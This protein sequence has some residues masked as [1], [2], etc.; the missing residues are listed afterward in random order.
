MKIS[1]AEGTFVFGKEKKKYF[2]YSLHKVKEVIY[3]VFKDNTKQVEMSKELWDVQTLLQAEESYLLTGGWTLNLQDQKMS[4]TDNIRRILNLNQ[5]TTPS[6]ELFVEKL[7]FSDS[8]SPSDIIAI[9][10]EQPGRFNNEADVLLDSGIKKHILLQADLSQGPDGEKHLLGFLHDTTESKLNKKDFGNLLSDLW[11]KEAF[12]DKLLFNETFF[13]MKI[14]LDGTFKSVNK[15]YSDLFFGP[16]PHAIENYNPME[17]IAIE[18]HGNCMEGVEKAL[19]NPGRNVKV[20]LRKYTWEKKEIFTRWDF[21][22]LVDDKNLPMEILCIGI[23]ITEIEE[24]KRELRV[25][26][27]LASKQ[28]TQLIEYNSILSHNIR[29]HVANLKGLSNLIELT[30]NPKDI[31][32]YFGLI[33]EAIG[34]LDQ[35]I[36]SFNYLNKPKIEGD[37]EKIPLSS[38]IAN[39]KAFFEEELNLIE[40]EFYTIGDSELL[41]TPFN[42]ILERILIQLISNCIKFRSPKRGLIIQIKVL[43]KA[44]NFK[45]SVQDNG[46]GIDLKRNNVNTYNSIEIKNLEPNSRGFGIFIASS[47]TESLG[48]NLKFISKKDLGTKINL[49]ISHDW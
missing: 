40:A 30:N 22:A 25:L 9:C 42:S 7:K 36:T 28:N 11:K 46:I 35:R 5:E 4:W 45:I 2:T 37:K 49:T 16:G 41:N 38:I 18:D 12:I 1:T 48:G 34:N 39:C 10:M 21:K 15:L 14:S 20:Y 29:N 43:K 3:L 6:W 47:L 17:D 27:D 24:K 8:Y 31:M 13:L 44:G 19:K 23:D 32:H 26:M 33:K